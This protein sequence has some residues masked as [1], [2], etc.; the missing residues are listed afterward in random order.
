MKSL[1]FT[2]EGTHVVELT[3]KVVK[4]VSLSAELQKEIAL[5]WLETQCPIRAKG[6]SE[7]NLAVEG[8]S[9]VLMEYITVSEGVEEHINHGEPSPEVIAYLISR[10]AIPPG[11][12]VMLHVKID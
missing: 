3:E 9:V 1:G 8:R 7:F 12:E 11:I 5:G 6:K 10:G 2:P 4:T